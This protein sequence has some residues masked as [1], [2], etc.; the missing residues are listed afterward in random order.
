MRLDNNVVLIWM[1]AIGV[2]LCLC[3]CMC[4]LTSDT[5]YFNKFSVLFHIMTII[6]SFSN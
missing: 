1:M 5:Y 4:V 3:A 6:T 2:K